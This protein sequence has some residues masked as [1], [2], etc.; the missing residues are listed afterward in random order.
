MSLVLCSPTSFFVFIGVCEWS[1]SGG[2]VGGGGG[3]RVGTR[4]RTEWPLGVSRP[5]LLLPP[6]SEKI[7]FPSWCFPKHINSEF[8]LL[9]VWSSTPGVQ[10]PFRYR[11]STLSRPPNLL[12]DSPV[13]RLRSRPDRDL[14]DR[15]SRPLWCLSLSGLDSKTFGRDHCLLLLPCPNT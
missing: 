5:I 3:T 15:S 6:L 7:D 8:T 12:L 11:G 14:P 4:R 2:G 1:I 9:K 13:R 10:T